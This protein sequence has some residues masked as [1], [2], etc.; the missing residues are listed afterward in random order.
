MSK[1][2]VVIDYSVTE[3]HIFN[4]TRNSATEEEVADF[5]AQYH[6]EIGTSFKLSQIDWMLVD[7]KN[8]QERLP[9]YIH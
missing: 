7:M 8:S 1:K 2:L 5:L 9:L 4:Y 6:T 3:V